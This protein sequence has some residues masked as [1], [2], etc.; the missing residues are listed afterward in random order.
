[1]AA[2]MPYPIMVLEGFGKIPINEVAYRL[3]STS[4]DREITLN[5][6]PFNRAT[7]ERP[8]AVILPIKGQGEPMPMQLAPL[9]IG[10]RCVSCAIRTR[11]G[12][13]RS[14]GCW[15]CGACRTVCMP[16]RSRGSRLDRHR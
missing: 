15:A 14:A 5:A 8:E 11:A 3:L 1:M 16:M 10:S 6:E 2:Q 9:D 12:S 7:G 4:P 13:A